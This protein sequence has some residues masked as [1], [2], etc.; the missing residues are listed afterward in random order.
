M[1]LNYIVFIAKPENNSRQSKFLRFFIIIIAV[2][3]GL[4]WLFRSVL[5][6]VYIKR[7][8]L[9]PEWI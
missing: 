6:L 5:N 9:A 8:I 2:I 3:F 7:D 1:Y 4:L